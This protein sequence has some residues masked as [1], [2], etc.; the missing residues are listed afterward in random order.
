MVLQET[1]L[2]VQGGPRS[3]E[4]SVTKEGQGVSLGISVVQVH[5]GQYLFSAPV[6]LHLE[7]Y[8]QLWALHF[9]K[10]MDNLGQIWVRATTVIRGL[11]NRTDKEPVLNW[12]CFFSLGE[13]RD[14][15]GVG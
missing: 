15:G 11:R 9:Q 14:R 6:R 3:R 10:D 2:A 5:P 13:G 12:G 1:T 4:H 8:V 7:H